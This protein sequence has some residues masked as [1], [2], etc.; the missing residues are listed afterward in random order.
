MQQGNKVPRFSILLFHLTKKRKIDN[1][2]RER[3]RREEFVTVGRDVK[4][5]K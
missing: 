5:S 3:G 4:T 2:V 1:G